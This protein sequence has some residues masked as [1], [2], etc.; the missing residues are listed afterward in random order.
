[1][2]KADFEVNGTKRVVTDWSWPLIYGGI[3]AF[4]GNQKSVYEY[5]K[6]TFYIVTNRSTGLSLSSIVLHT[7]DEDSFT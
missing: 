5:L 1:M 4:K 3:R 7:L 2:V 6:D